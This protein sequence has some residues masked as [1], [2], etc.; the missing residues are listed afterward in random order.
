MISKLEKRGLVLR[1]PCEE[2]RRVTM[3]SLTDE[4]SLTPYIQDTTQSN[5]SLVSFRAF[6]GGGGSGTV[7]GPFD[8]IR[9]GTTFASV[10]SAVPEPSTYAL[11]AGL[12]ALFAGF[13]Y[14]RRR[15][16]RS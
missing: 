10:T 12:V 1:S 5:I 15:V 9:F 13:I 7:A 16:A 3:V 14:R 6:A 8:E 11:G 2:S 4:G